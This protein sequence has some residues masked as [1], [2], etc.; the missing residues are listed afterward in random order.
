MYK[1]IKQHIQ[2]TNRLSFSL[3]ELLRLECRLGPIKR[4]NQLLLSRFDRF[5][6]NPTH[7]WAAANRSAFDL[8]TQLRAD[9]NLKTPD[10]LH[11]AVAISSGCDEFWTND[12]RLAKAAAQ[13]INIVTFN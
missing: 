2:N 13:R 12:F 9:H 6:A 7:H 5:F 10:A 1:K 11:L 4:G 8:A 3:A